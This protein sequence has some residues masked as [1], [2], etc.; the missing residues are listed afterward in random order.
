MVVSTVRK[1]IY[2]LETLVI[3]AQLKKKKG[4]EALLNH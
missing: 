4:F 2:I 1:N 3:I